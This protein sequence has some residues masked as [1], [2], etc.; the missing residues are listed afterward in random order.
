MR[1]LACVGGC[2]LSRE[3]QPRALLTHNPGLV[4][5]GEGAVSGPYYARRATSN[6][7]PDDDAPDA[8]ALTQSALG[9]SQ[10]GPGDPAVMGPGS[11]MTLHLRIQGRTLGPRPSPIFALR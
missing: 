1:R 8:Q 10:Q 3:D 2:S 6:A 11:F 9:A 7:A 4:T 5:D